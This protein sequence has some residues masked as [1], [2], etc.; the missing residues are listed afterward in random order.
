MELKERFQSK[1]RVTPGCW[2]WTAGVNQQGYGLIQVAGKL[3]KAHRVSYELHHGPIKP[4]LVV[5][6]KCDTPSCVNPDHL[7]LG[8]HKQNAEDRD[9]RGRNH[10]A[11]KTHCPRDHEYTPENTSVTRAGHRQ[12]RTCHADRERARRANR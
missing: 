9:T 4:G 3:R 10:H 7:E 8:T 6:H 2:T 11:R 5:R 12:C 1:L